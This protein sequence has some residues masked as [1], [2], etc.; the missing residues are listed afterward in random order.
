MVTK[1]PLSSEDIIV[2]ARKAYITGK[3]SDLLSGVCGYECPLHYSTPAN[4][5]TDFE[6]VIALGIY[7]LYEQDNDAGVHSAYT[8]AIVK[9][10]AGDPEQVWIAY[11]VALFQARLELQNI[12]PFKIVTPELVKHIKYNINKNKALLTSIF[13][14]QGEGKKEGLWQDIATTNK[15]LF[16]DTGISFL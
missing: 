13:K 5:P 8:Y 9:L 6:R 2:L 3:I 16:D 1:Q 4:V 11:M 14:W 15:G 10:A 7:R 12:S